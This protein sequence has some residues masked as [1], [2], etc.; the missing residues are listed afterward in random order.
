MSIQKGIY[1]HFKGTLYAVEG[2]CLHTE[3]NE[4]LVLY[5]DAKDHTKKYAR[6]L[7]MFLAKVEHEGNIVPRFDFITVEYVLG[8]TGEI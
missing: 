7:S 6:P 4:V 5:S 1:K 3:T 8:C 2:T